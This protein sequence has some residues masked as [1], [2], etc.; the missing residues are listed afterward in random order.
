MSAFPSPL[1]SPTCTSTQV[2]FGFQLVQSEFVKEEPLETA[3]HQLPLFKS[4]P[5][6]SVRPSPL[7]SPATTS[8]QVTAGFQAPSKE[9]VNDE[10]VE[11][12]FQIWPLSLTRPVI[13]SG[14]KSTPSENSEV[15]PAGSVAVAVMIGSPEMGVK[16]KVNE[17]FP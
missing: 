9:L 12:P 16:L 5:A 13:S 6:M 14:A 11:T 7:K 3:T 4:R 1:K 8:T 10:P 17:A 2:T 15:L